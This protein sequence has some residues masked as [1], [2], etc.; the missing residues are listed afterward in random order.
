MSHLC[1]ITDSREWMK[2]RRVGIVKIGQLVDFR[3]CFGRWITGVIKNF[4]SVSEVVIK[5]KIENC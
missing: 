5:Y 1:K 2:K 4:I 3:T